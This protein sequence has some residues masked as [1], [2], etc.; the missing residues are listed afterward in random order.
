MKEIIIYTYNRYLGYKNIIIIITLL[1][2]ILLYDKY[3]ED[4]F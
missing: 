2:P 4:I 3:D 1:L